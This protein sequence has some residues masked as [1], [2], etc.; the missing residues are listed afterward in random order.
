[1]ACIERAAAVTQPSRRLTARE[2]EVL[3]LVERGRTN[4]EIARRMGIRR[5]TVARH[6]SNAMDKLGAESRAHAVVIHG[7]T[8]AVPVVSAVSP[9]IRPRAIDDDGRAILARLAVG[10]TLGAIAHELHLSRRTAD[11]RLAEARAA[12]GA[13]RTTQAVALAQRLGWFA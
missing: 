3:R 13:E 9:G 7:A 10:R 1:M 11:R 12:L 2:R 4:S 5:P 6:L 8:T